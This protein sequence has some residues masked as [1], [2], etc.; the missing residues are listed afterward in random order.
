M[1][2]QDVIKKLKAAGY[3]AEKRSRTGRDYVVIV[4]D[5]GTNRS[6]LLKN[7]IAPKL[8]GI[9]KQV[10]TFSRKGE[11]SVNNVKIVAKEKTKVQLVGLDARLFTKGGNQ[12]K[13]MYQGKDVRC[14][15]FTSAK[16][17]EQSIL[18][19]FD[20]NKSL[21]GDAKDAVEKFF[22]N[23]VFGW[24]VIEPAVIKKLAV[25]LGEVLIG[26]AALTGQAARYVTGDNP[27]QGV[28]EF[29][30]PDDPSFSGV[31][32]FFRLNNG[33]LLGMG[34][35]VAISSKSGAGRPGSFFSNV[36]PS[37]IKAD[38]KGRTVK[39]LASII[40]RKG[41]KPTDAKSIVYEWGVNTI[42][43]MG[44]TDPSKVVDDL[45]MH[46]KT[47]LAYQISGNLVDEMKRYEGDPSAKER[48]DK[49]PLSITSC[50]NYLLA[51]RLED[52]MDDIQKAVIA[53][54]FFQANLDQSMFLKGQLH[55]SIRKAGNSQVKMIFKQS[56]IAD[57]AARN[58]WVNYEIRRG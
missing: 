8:K 52:S 39:Q 7:K 6:E 12:T 13:I 14:L 1:T 19:G 35:L 44:I 24:G 32:T 30:V 49:L 22:S 18:K 29:L 50:F 31:D 38:P 28:V 25:Y 16:Q 48:I 57:A 11:V 55:Y 4:V 5:P 27:F 9:F 17:L 56:P 40:Q 41:Y 10:G 2:L 23:G 37:V 33:Q 53:K 21:R 15:S 51:K 43:R 26:W 54:G 3:N 46:K 20:L 42:L 47:R 58:G 45:K 36:L 34:D